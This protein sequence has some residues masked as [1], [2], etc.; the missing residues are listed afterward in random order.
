MLTPN[1][2]PL[3]P[4]LREPVSAV[5]LDRQGWDLL[6]RQARQHRVLGRLESLLRGQN[7]LEQAP[8]RARD[9]L[10]AARAVADRHALGMQWEIRCMRQVLAG[11]G[12][13]VVLLKGAAYVAASLPPARGRLYSDIDLMVPKASL[14][15]VE[16]TL[17]TNGW[18]PLVMHPYDQRY[19][20]TWMHELPPMVHRDRGTVL[21]LHHTIL[22][23]TGR[24]H[25]APE[26]L[27]EAARPIDDGCFLILAPADL[28]LHSAAH[29]FQDG[30]PSGG[31]R[32]LA[33]LDDLLRHFDRQEG[34]AFWD[35]LAPRARELDLARPL[36]YTLGSCRRFL[37]TPVPEPVIQAI[38]ADAPGRL[39]RPI[40]DRLMTRALHA[41]HPERRSP[42]GEFCRWMLYVR[43]HW[44]RMPPA[45]LVCHLARKAWR[46][47]VGET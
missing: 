32:D 9:H 22:P 28:V 35:A 17:L 4:V 39:I 2:S 45:L 42:G 1:A 18:Q 11:V 34:P 41:E 47:C 30:D 29:L 27:F 21:D 40:M 38:E 23:E 20:R 24:V 5:A 33:D 7:L 31:L 16:R 12:V 44:L 37:A 6:V 10:A 36:Y 46:R 3:W 13:P 14:A 25:P 8:S 15:R 43:S 19:Y 26:K